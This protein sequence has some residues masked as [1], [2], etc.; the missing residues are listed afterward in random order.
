[1]VKSDLSKYYNTIVH[2]RIILAAHMATK[3]H[4]ITKSM[5]VC[6]GLYFYLML[7][8]CIALNHLDK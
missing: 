6:G 2:F 3:L 1:M 4:P 8:L 5:V 7:L